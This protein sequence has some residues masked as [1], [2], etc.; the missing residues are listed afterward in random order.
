M[1]GGKGQGGKAKLAATEN[2]RLKNKN[3]PSPATH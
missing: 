2:K 3:S 1:R